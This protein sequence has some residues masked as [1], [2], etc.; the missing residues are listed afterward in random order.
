MSTSN[1]K[2]NSFH[3]LAGCRC[4]RSKGHEGRCWSKAGSDSTGAI[5]RCE[6][7]SINGRYHRHCEYKTSYSR[8]ARRLK[9]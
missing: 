1:E 8:N 5:T 4:I 9:P 7:T 2:C 3:E 6:W